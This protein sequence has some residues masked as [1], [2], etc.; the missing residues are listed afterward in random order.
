MLTVCKIS[1]EYKCVLNILI[2]NQTK[3]HWSRFVRVKSVL[4]FVKIIEIIV[5]FSRIFVDTQ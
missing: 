2:M 4:R 5:A 3:L 1:F